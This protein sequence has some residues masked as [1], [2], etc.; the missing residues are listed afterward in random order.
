MNLDKW[1]QLELDTIRGRGEGPALDLVFMY[2][3]LWRRGRRDARGVYWQQMRR[4][5]MLYG[6]QLRRDCDATVRWCDT[7]WKK[8]SPLYQALRYTGSPACLVVSPI[9]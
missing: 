8:D 2:A 9:S 6:L 1:E 7:F 5:E 4:A 3:L